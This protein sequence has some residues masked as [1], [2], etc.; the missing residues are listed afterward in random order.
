MLSS[1]ARAL[2][3]GDA[4]GYLAPLESQVRATEQAIA[5][6]ATGV[7]IEEVRFSVNPSARPH[8]ENSFRSARV[9]LVLRYQGLP[10][11]NFFRV[12]FEYDLERRQLGWA[13]TNS[14]VVAGSQ[15]PI[16]ATGPIA[17]ARFL[18]FLA[19]FRPGLPGPQGVLDLA[20]RARVGLVEK[21]T[22]PLDE[23][24]L[25]LLAATRA[26]Y[27][28]MTEGS[29][30]VSAVAR[31]ETTYEISREKITA[32]GRQIVVNL[33]LLGSGETALETLRHE[34]AHLA[35]FRD[36]RPFTPAWVG[37]SAA[38]YLAGTRP[39]STWRRG[40]RQGRFDQISFAELNRAAGLG[41]HDPLGVAASFE[42]AY[43][44]AAAWYLTEEFGSEAYWTFYRYYAQVPAD[45]VY[46]R[47]PT[48]R[49]SEALGGLAHE[50]TGSA[51]RQ[52]FG[53]DEAGLDMR[54]RS[55]IRDQ[56]R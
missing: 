16:W 13:V 43:A 51:L 20:E 42:Y 10:P 4:E 17:T 39:V 14:T 45:E 19:F 33:E 23:T 27:Q 7:P 28:Q 41:L 54:V 18:H 56:A 52:V 15:L 25:V 9:D 46:D 37:E 32:E 1:R 40:I 53:L 35:L 12:Q 8:D 44:A 21:L 24:H 49:E 22:F 30:P 5:A 47:I 2:L 26:E 48:G 11:D 38:M 36:T 50:T 34:L 6:G 31:A 29:V 3:A 55:W